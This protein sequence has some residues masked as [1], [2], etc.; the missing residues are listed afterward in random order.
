MSPH[1]SDF[2]PIQERIRQKHGMVDGA[3]L[4]ESQVEDQSLRAVPFELDADLFQFVDATGGQPLDGHTG[5]DSVVCGKYL[6]AADRLQRDNSTRDCQHTSFL[7]VRL[8]QINRDVTSLGAAQQLDDTFERH[9]PGRFTVDG[10][11]GITIQ[12]TDGMSWSIR[13]HLHHRGRAVLH[14]ELDASPH[15]AIRAK[16]LSD[17]FIL[18]RHEPY[19]TRNHGEHPGAHCLFEFFQ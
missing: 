3:G 4:R 2:L 17:A 15:V 13:K 18:G 14:R 19:L 6:I 16:L 12:C 7:F 10:L 1:A 9:T 8:P 11:N 5:H